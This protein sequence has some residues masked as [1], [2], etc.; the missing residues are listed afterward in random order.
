[1]K[2]LL[3][4]FL[5]LLPVPKPDEVME[6]WGSNHHPSDAPKRHVQ[7]V[8]AAKLS[9]SVTQG[10]TMDGTNCRSPIGVGMG[11]WPA[12]E[13]TW[14]SN[15]TVRMENIGESDV[16]NPWLSNKR[17]DFRTIDE[18]AAGALAPNMTDKEKAAA[19]WFQEIRF[20]HHFDGDNNELGDP[21]KVYN[22]YGY[23]TCG[24][25][26]MCLAGLWKKAG[27]KVA[28]ARLVGHCVSQV[29]YDGRWHALDGDMHSMY[30]LRDNETVAGEQDLVRDHDLVRRSHTQGILK[31][32]IRPDDEWES[33]IYVYEGD[34]NG[35]RN[36]NDKTTMNMVLRPS[37]SITWRWGHANPVKHHGQSKPHYPDT[38]CNGLWEYKPDFAK[39]LW[40]KGAAS[41]ENVHAAGGELSAEGD[42]TGT[43]VWIVRSPYVYVGGKVESEGTGAKFSI[44]WDG[45]SW[46]DVDRDLDKKFP[47]EGTAHYEYQLR[48]QLTGSARLKSLRIVNDLQMAPLAL[49]GMMVG[50]NAFTYTD[51]S[52]G[53]RKVRITHEWVER[54][55]SKPPEA[56]PSPLFPPEGGESKGTDVV[57]RWTPPKDGDGDKVVDYHFELSDRADL[58]WPLSTNFYKLI[59]K[60]PDK[61]KAQYSLPHV[62]LLAPDRR[63]YWHV[64]AKD[65]KGVWGPWSKAWSFTPRAPTSPTEVTLDFD[66]NK[67]TGLLRWKAGP[68][69]RKPAKYRIY[70]SDEKGFSVSDDPYKVTV[71]ISKDVP[72]TLPANFVSEIAESELAVVGRELKLPNA[73]RAYYRVVAVDDQG[74]RSGP[75]DLA[76]A[77]RSFIYSKPPAKAKVG[78]EYRYPL[79]AVR[80][81]GDLRT[82]VVNGREVMNYWDIETPRFAL[83]QGPAWLKMDEK[84]GL[85]S[86]IPEAAGKVEVKVSV[87]LENEARKLDEKQLMWGVEKVVTSSPQKVGTGTQDF[88]IDVEPQ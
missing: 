61:G 3:V 18:I 83:V 33:S 72:S 19:L 85:L 26:S 44:S 21:V 28:P 59:S 74:S 22:V 37:E 87:A 1:M 41:V 27:L 24:N 13:Q 51:Q 82:R 20:R 47:P 65:E 30:L 25:D 77:P 12:I 75:S 66:S 73:N 63:Y 14:E 2:S 50:P 46:E 81:L 43:I 45:K 53:P 84:T 49:P 79:A 40:R 70:G 64:R 31:P 9:Y 4:L 55:A 56:P 32:D 16:I 52:Q 68:S 15:R 88:V 78:S 86:G 10:G 6:P 5:A 80:S 54:S 67:G 39:E 8:A 36:C 7:D 35:D 48:C 42:K 58:K 76:A 29:F 11:S 60:T 71:G 23:N 38:I 34:V 62:G 69:G 17:N 57:F